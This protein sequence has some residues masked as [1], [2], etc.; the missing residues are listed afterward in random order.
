M[1]RIYDMAILGGGPAGYTAA[2]Y[3]ARAG[4]SVAIIE[5]MA[6]GGQMTQTAQIENYP[7]H[8]DGIDGFTLGSKMQAGAERFGAET[9]YAEITAARLGGE[10]KEIETS[11]GTYRA[12]T[13]V[14]ATGADPK[15]LGAAGEEALLGRGVHTCAHCDG[16]FYR[17]RR[18]AV[19]GG[20]NSAAADVLLLSR[21]A[22]R[23]TVIHRRDALRAERHSQ[24]ALSKAENVEFLWNASVLSLEKGE[25]GVLLSLEDTQTGERRCLLVDGVFVS[26]GRRPATALFEGQLLLDNEGYIVA[27]ETTKTNLPGVYAVGDVRQKP[28]RQI[29]TAV[30]D[31]A[32]AAHFAEEFLSG[33]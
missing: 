24:E 30:G 16:R 23:V 31:G 28:L 21:L 1:E 7:G 5:R 12:R 14:I 2:L 29:V 26:I 3:A 17:G 27:D 32:V 8:E 6:A 33:M 13:A 19:V 25:E 9:V 15:R 4:L 20:G 22:S 10:V 11:M 18:V